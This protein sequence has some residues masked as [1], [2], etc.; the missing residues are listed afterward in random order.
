MGAVFTGAVVLNIFRTD[1]GRLAIGAAAAG[2]IFAIDPLVPLGM[3]GGVSYVAVVLFGLW[4]AWPPAIFIL[5]GLG[6]VLMV[7]GHYL[8]P[9]ADGLDHVAADHTLAMA[10]IWMVVVLVHGRRINRERILDTSIIQSVGALVIILDRDGNIRRCNRTTEE[11]TGRKQDRLAGTPIQDLIEPGDGE[12]TTPAVFDA[13]FL[14]RSPSRCESF[15]RTADGNRRRISWSNTPYFG[16]RGDLDYIILAGIDVTEQYI[17]RESLGR[18]EELHRNVVENQIDLIARSLPDGTLTFV[19]DV[20]CRFYGMTREQ[21]IGRNMI[22]LMGGD[23]RHVVENRIRQRIVSPVWDP[24]EVRMVDGN[25]DVHWLNWAAKP[26]I[27]EGGK[28]IEYQ[29]AGRDVTERRRAENALRES[30]ERHRHLTNISPD[31]IMVQCGGRIV[32]ANPAAVR[33]YG[34]EKPEDLIGRETLDLVHP[35][36]H[37][38][39]LEQ[40]KEFSGDKAGPAILEA[41]TR[42]RLDGSEFLGDGVGTPFVWGG[43]VATLCVVHDVTEL[44]RTEAELKTAIETAEKATQ[45]KSRFLAAASHDLRQPLFALSLFLTTLVERLEDPSVAGI[46]E[47]MEQS[48]ESANNLLNTVLDLSKLD[49]GV[50]EPNITGFPIQS[51]LDQTAMEFAPIAVAAQNSLTVMPCRL[52]VRSDKV[53][54]ESIV[55]NLVSNAVR[56]TRVGRILVGCR[57]RGDALRIVVQDTGPGIPADKHSE[58]FREFG[59]LYPLPETETAGLGLGLAIVE[60]TARL[61]GSDIVLQSD[62]GKGSV[63]AFELPLGDMAVAA[64][65]AAESANFT[66]SPNL[67]KAVVALIEDDAGIRFAIPETLRNWGCECITAESTSRVIDELEAAGRVPDLILADYHL[68][69]GET[70][71]NG[72]ERLRSKWGGDIPAVIVSADTSPETARLVSDAGIALLTKPVQPAKLRSLLQHLLQTNIDEPLARMTTA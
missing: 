17:A 49:A 54:V 39:I 15:I 7:A 44:R 40:R 3:A 27:G 37:R 58:I 63:F 55:R 2:A 14:S 67:S 61:L 64:V 38:R 50:V 53:L 20:Y 19:N 42:R 21:L 69:L 26:I 1:A 35:E 6:T 70:G 29:S 9:A 57:R 30:E 8:W 16:A 5:A 31:A 32:F 11:V 36:D 22:E 25:G 60:R 65:P 45:A 68:G 24:I 41:V 10:A 71:L 51:I 72:I 47:K 33:M 13:D 62:L 28:I 4:I 18:S 56:Y 12:K 23:D 52:I 46:L 43:D 59:R 34:A 48:L 66:A